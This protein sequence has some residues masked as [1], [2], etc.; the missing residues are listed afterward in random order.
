MQ[1]TVQ[2]DPVQ[3]IMLKRYLNK[4]GKAQQFFTSEFRK[5]MDPYVPFKNGPLKNTATEKNNTIT[6]GQ[7]YSR[8]QLYENK[9]R[10][11]RGKQWHVRAWADRG[12]MVVKAVANFV[13][14]K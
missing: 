1:V 12:N 6:Y 11:L 14:G 9:G 4:N 10:G 3:K 7:P 5:A 2:I 13:G 8:R